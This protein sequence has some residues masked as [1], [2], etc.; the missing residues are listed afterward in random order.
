[1]T[2]QEFLERFKDILTIK[3]ERNSPSVDE[4]FFRFAYCYGLVFNEKIYVVGG[5]VRDKVRGVESKDVDIAIDSMNTESPNL[6]CTLFIEVNALLG[7]TGF[8]KAPAKGHSLQLLCKGWK[9]EGYDIT[10]KPNILLQLEHSDFTMNGL[11]IDITP[12]IAV[13]KAREVF[14]QFAW[15]RT[16][17]PSVREYLIYPD[18]FLQDAQTG[19]LRLTPYSKQTK[20]ADIALRGLKF[21]EREFR[22]LQ[23][24][25]CQVE[26]ETWKYLLANQVYVG[27]SGKLMHL[28]AELMR[29]NRNINRLIPLI[30][31]WRQVYD[32]PYTVEAFKSYMSK[33][34]KD[35]PTNEDIDNAFFAALSGAFSLLEKF[36]IR[37]S[38]EKKVEHFVAYVQKEDALLAKTV[39]VQGL[40]LAYQHM[41]QDPKLRF[42]QEAE[43]SKGKNIGTLMKILSGK[44][45]W[46]EN[47][48]GDADER[49]YSCLEVF[50]ERANF[51]SSIAQTLNI[52]NLRNLKVEDLPKSLPYAREDVRL[53]AMFADSSNIDDIMAIVSQ[54]NTLKE[55][56]NLLIRALIISA[57]S[58]AKASKLGNN[59]ASTTRAQ[60]T[61]LV[62]ASKAFDEFESKS[63]AM[64][65]DLFLEC[66]W[67]VLAACNALR[68][69]KYAN[70]IY[71]S[72]PF[73]QMR[74][75]FNRMAEQLKNKEFLDYLK[76]PY[77]PL[78]R[79][80]IVRACREAN[81]R[82]EPF[83]DI[84]SELKFE[85]V[86]A[87]TAND[88]RELLASYVSNRRAA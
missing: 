84:L 3:V 21:F 8:F 1:M 88:A 34:T 32:G 20:L 46:L 58:I 54:T 60:R 40:M 56:D 73:A 6:F 75:V 71:T 50:N 52:K 76:D 28:Y 81:M 69:T 19:I 30:R 35:L 2:P 65:L 4:F 12:K 17:S 64:S 49:L 36:I 31:A 26:P 45:K 82:F 70:P 83:F 74:A 13:E 22:S 11:A 53:A 77:A 43:A 66:V 18:E 80:E 47:F 61:L 72:V 5:Y 57:Q 78:S 59:N 33:F 37:K 85:Q 10:L 44:A 67:R 79:Q 24:Q 63:A 14:S 9:R 51:I 86:Q 38:P 68:G 27:L 42:V 48:E 16:L 29:K 87:I 7:R 41:E 15:Q 25:G 23:E 55:F 39:G 62:N